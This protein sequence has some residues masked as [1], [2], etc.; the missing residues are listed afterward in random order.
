MIEEL[1]KLTQRV[2]YEQL[3][4]DQA[5]DFYNK[6]G[7]IQQYA[8]QQVEKYKEEQLKRKTKNR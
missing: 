7:L 4:E 5:E 1:E 8:D 2:A 6:M 3:G